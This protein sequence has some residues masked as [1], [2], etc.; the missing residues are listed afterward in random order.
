MCEDEQNQN[1]TVSGLI[2]DQNNDPVEYA[3][4]ILYNVSNI[5]GHEKLTPIAFTKTNAKG[6]YLF[7]NVPKGVYKIKS[8]KM[9][10]F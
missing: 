8:T 4:V 3:D 9:S 1:G 5:D 7:I 2:T 6:V 10:D